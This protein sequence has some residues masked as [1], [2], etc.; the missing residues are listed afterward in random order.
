MA[1]DNAGHQSN[2]KWETIEKIRFFCGKNKSLARAGWCRTPA[3]ALAT[4]L[5]K[6]SRGHVVAS[7]AGSILLPAKELDFDVWSKTTLLDRLKF[8]DQG[9]PM[10]Y[11]SY[12]LVELDYNQII[13]GFVGALNNK[14]AK[15][16]KIAK[17]NV[18]VLEPAT[19][20]QKIMPSSPNSSNVI[21]QITD[22]PFGPHWG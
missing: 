8:V 22:P 7:P 6:R 11:S 1:R 17:K 4:I 15:K 2:G 21:N 9:R 10:R 3:P 14:Y 13:L 20:K 16:Y 5:K 12:A 19:R 18:V